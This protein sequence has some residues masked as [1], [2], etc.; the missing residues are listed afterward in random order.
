MDKH[1]FP[2][3]DT[4]NSVNGA[5]NSIIFAD[6]ILKWLP[7][8]IRVRNLLLTLA[9]ALADDTHEISIHLSSYHTYPSMKRNKTKSFIWNKERRFF[10]LF[11]D[12][13]DGKPNLLP[14]AF[15]ISMNNNDHRAEPVGNDD[16]GSREDEFD[17]MYKDYYVPKSIEEETLG[18]EEERYYDHLDWCKEIQQQKDLTLEQRQNLA[19]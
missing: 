1:N 8:Q 9:N 2:T 7:K 12:I 14:K 17:F 3:N 10:H 4:K 5:E 16:I 15:G 11:L 6:Y 18:D 19:D 13:L